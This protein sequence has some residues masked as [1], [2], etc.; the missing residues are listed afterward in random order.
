MP[1]Q[2]QNP[3]DIEALKQFPSSNMTYECS[4]N[5]LEDIPHIN[6]GITS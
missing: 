2:I 6:D 5:C 4:S 3:F 1:K